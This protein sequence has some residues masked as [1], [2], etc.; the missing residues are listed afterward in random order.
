MYAISFIPPSF[1]DT[2]SLNDQNITDEYIKTLVITHLYLGAEVCRSNL[3]HHL[4]TTPQK[5]HASSG[6]VNCYH[7][8]NSFLLLP[9]VKMML[10]KLD[11]LLEYHQ[12]MNNKSCKKSAETDGDLLRFRDHGI[13]SVKLLIKVLKSHDLISP[14]Y[15]LELLKRYC[16][17]SILTDYEYLMPALMPYIG[18]SKSRQQSPSFV[19]RFLTA[20]LPI[21]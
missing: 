5:K 14:E 2:C 10:S 18:M 16:A 8:V 6:L 15:M 21:F 17:I 4:H 7:Q 19:I 11:E 9:G 12:N 3:K 13:L 1:R 20:L